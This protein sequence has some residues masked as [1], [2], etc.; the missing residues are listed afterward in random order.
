MTEL[1]KSNVSYVKVKV[2]VAQSF[3]TLCDPVDFSPSGSSVHGIFQ[4]RILERVAISFSG[5]Y[6]PFMD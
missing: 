1:T 2:L 4:S 5:G 3:L 6:S